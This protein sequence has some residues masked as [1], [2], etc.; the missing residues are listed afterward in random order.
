[1]IA[2]LRCSRKFL[3]YLA[4]FYLPSFNLLKIIVNYA[5]NLFSKMSTKLN[6]A[7]FLTLFSSYSMCGMISMSILTDD[8]RALSLRSECTVE[9]ILKIPFSEGPSSLMAERANISDV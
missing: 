7:C 2:F 8:P 5:Q 1:M 6:V 4:L 9:F 3:I